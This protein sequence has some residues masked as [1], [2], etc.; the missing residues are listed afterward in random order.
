MTRIRLNLDRLILRGVEPLEAKALAET[1][2]S[3]LL[4]LL[5]ERERRKQ[6]ARSHRTPLLKL[7]RIPLQAGITGARK[8]GAQMAD[9]IGRGLKP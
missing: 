9:A 4:E 2:Q 1:L 8:F 7:G 6:W 3:Q 5:A